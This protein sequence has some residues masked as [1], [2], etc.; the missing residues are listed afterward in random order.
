LPAKVSLIVL[1]LREEGIER[2]WN[3]EAW[4]ANNDKITWYIIQM[5]P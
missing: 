2:T 3:G 1:G 4:N 5:F